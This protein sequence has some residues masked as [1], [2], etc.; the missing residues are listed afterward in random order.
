M[1]NSERSD[2]DDKQQI[3]NS[4]VLKLMFLPGGKRGG[5][6]FNSLFQDSG[7]FQI[8]QDKWDCDVSGSFR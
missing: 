1:Y 4:D 6:L 7:L 5:P 8:S 2:A 3:I